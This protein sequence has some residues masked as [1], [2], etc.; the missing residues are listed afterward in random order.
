MNTPPR[1]TA[2]TAAGVPCRAS[3][4][5]GKALCRWHD[6]D[7]VAKAK[8]KAESA[9]GGTTKAYGNLPSIGALAENPA[10]AALDLSTVAGLQGLLSATLGSLARLPFDLRIATCISQV[11]QSQRIVVV[12]AD[13]DARLKILE[14]GQAG[15]PK[16]VARS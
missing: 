9:K 2:T 3:P 12:D 14:A 7:P 15:G 13:F 6:T 5:A 11:A 8:H 4:A 1:C 16:L 10:V